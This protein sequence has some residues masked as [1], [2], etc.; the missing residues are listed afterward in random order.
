MNSFKKIILNQSHFECLPVCVFNDIAFFLAYTCTL[1]FLFFLVVRVRELNRRNRASLQRIKP[2][3]VF[4]PNPDL[5]KVQNSKDDSAD[6]PQ[7]FPQQGQS[8]ANANVTQGKL[9]STLPLSFNCILN[10]TN[11]AQSLNTLNDDI[12]PLAKSGVLEGNE[13]C[14][15]SRVLVSAIPNPMSDGELLPSDQFKSPKR[16]R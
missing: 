15:D 1:F 11:T 8:V 14:E 16:K 7:N 9:D 13:L 5:V 4:V 10:T 3:S 6:S 12:Q 2:N